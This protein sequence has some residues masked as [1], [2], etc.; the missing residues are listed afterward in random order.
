MSNQDDNKSVDNTLTIR[1]HVY[2]TDI[3]VNNIPRD[4]EEYYR[5]AAKL[6]TE[7][8]NTY[9]SVFK[10]SRTLKEVIL[11]AFVDVALQFVLKQYEANVGPYTKILT[12]LTGEIE[13][14]LGEPE[15]NISF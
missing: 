6:I 9:A 14:V 13:E 1:L 11:M 3:V 7:K 2:D 15:Q 12:K 5:S 8:I 4:D 10:G